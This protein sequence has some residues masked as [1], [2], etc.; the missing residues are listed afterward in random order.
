MWRHPPDHPSLLAELDSDDVNEFIQE[1]K[2]TKFKM[3]L[4]QKG[5]LRRLVKDIRENPN[6]Y[7]Y[8][9]SLFSN[10]GK[11]AKD[12][13]PQEIPDDG[14]NEPLESVLERVKLSQYLE[15][16]TKQGVSKLA[17]LV[18][19]DAKT[20]ETTFVQ[21][22]LKSGHRMRLRRAVGDHK[23]KG[24]AYICQMQVKSKSAKFGKGELGLGTKLG[25][26]GQSIAADGKEVRYGVAMHPLARGT[27]FAE[28]EVPGSTPPGVLCGVCAIDDSAKR[29]LGPG[30]NFSVSCDGTV[31]QTVTGVKNKVSKPFGFEWS[32]GLGTTVRLSVECKGMNM[33]AYAVWVDPR[34]DPDGEAVVID[35]PAVAPTPVPPNPGPLPTADQLFSVGEV[36]PPAPGGRRA[37][38]R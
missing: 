7:Y 4:G 34:I 28:F 29:M 19:M 38:L 22:G 9:Q 36:R 21:A 16:L 14:S 1:L 31:I 10:D 6:K 30:V 8:K 32:P 18:S 17:D 5:K 15:P 13:K 2:G 37:M 35:G 24:P 23:S 27:V 26:K 33:N 11:D 12:A 3:T 20:L 25:I